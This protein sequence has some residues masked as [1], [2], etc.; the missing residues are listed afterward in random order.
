MKAYYALVLM[1]DVGD[2]DCG[3]PYW[4]SSCHDEVCCQL[5]RILS[6]RCDH[7]ALACQR[8]S[9]LV[10]T[11]PPFY[12]PAVHSGVQSQRQLVGPP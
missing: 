12:V 11:N 10:C 6:G 2:A 4:T 9:A 1:R 5:V 8:H 3:H 7:D